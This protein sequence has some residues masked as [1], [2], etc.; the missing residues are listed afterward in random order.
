MDQN[1]RVFERDT[2]RA[3]GATSHDRHSRNGPHG[4]SVYGLSIY[5][6]MIAVAAL[7]ADCDTLSSKDIHDGIVLD[8]RVHFALCTD[9]NR[10]SRVSRIG[11]RRTGGTNG[12][13][14]LDFWI[15]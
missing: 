15:Y 5:D 11:E 13:P 14:P 1:L 6:A 7:H 3:S 8:D 4:C 2:W 9:A 10:G 12:R